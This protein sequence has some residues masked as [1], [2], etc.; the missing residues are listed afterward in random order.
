M[1][2]L[3]VLMKC[4]KSIKNWKKNIGVSFPP[5]MGVMIECLQYEKS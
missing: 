5:F 4:L 2:I 1:S 3:S